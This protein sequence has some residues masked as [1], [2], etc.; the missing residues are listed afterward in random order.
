MSLSLDVFPG[1]EDGGGGE[2]RG[3]NQVV[4]EDDFGGMTLTDSLK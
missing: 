2:G 1:G 3:T 4:S